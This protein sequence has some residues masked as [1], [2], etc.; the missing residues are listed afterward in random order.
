MTYSE[1]MALPVK[2][3]GPLLKLLAEAKDNDACLEY[4]KLIFADKYSGTQS[5]GQSKDDAKAEARS[6]AVTFLYEA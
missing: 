1:V 3:Q 4:A 2:E 5:E 6:S